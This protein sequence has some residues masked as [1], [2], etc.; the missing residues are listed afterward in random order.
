[1]IV[2]LSL[3]YLGCGL[4]TLGFVVWAELDRRK[5]LISVNRWPET[6][7]EKLSFRIKVYVAV[8]LG[9]PLYWL[10]FMGINP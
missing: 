2:T 10:L 7:P 3:I 9:W 6:N 8:V 4:A 5:F 1:M